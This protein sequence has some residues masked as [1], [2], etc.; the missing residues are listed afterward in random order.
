MPLRELYAPD[1]VFRHLPDWPE[2]GPTAC[3]G[4][5]MPSSKRALPPDSVN[6]VE[7][8]VVPSRSPARI[9]LVPKLAH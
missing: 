1:I 8:A 5:A 7:A 9:V 3:L 6:R 2:P 4:Q